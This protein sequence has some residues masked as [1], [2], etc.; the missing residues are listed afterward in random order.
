MNGYVI[1]IWLEARL[2]R[3]NKGTVIH[4]WNTT[5]AGFNETSWFFAVIGSG[6]IFGSLFGLTGVGAVALTFGAFYGIGR[7]KDKIVG[8]LK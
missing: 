6:A 2:I 7:T 1:G 5:K 3:M 4:F 8:G